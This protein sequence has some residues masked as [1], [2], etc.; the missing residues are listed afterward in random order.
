MKKK[1]FIGVGITIVIILILILTCF[2]SFRNSARYG[3]YQLSLAAKYQ[4]PE[5]ALEYYNIDKLVENTLMRASA[6]ID[7]N[8]SFLAMM[9]MGLISQL[10]ESLPIQYKQQL[11]EEYSKKDEK[12]LQMSDLKIFYYA[13]INKPLTAEMLKTEKLSRNKVKQSFCNSQGHKCYN[14]TW[15]K[16]YNAWKVTDIEITD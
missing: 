4:K 2:L 1:I 16:T 13:Y 6:E 10:K 15:E 9:Q 14:R 5:L 3:A 8:D 7:S 12:L 11:T